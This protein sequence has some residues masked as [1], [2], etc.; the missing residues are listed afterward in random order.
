[1]CRQLETRLLAQL[2][3]PGPQVPG[4]DQTTPGEAVPEEDVLDHAAA[5]DEQQLLRDDRDAVREGGSGRGVVDRPSV[6]DQ[7]ALVRLDEPGDHATEGRLAR[8]VL[9]HE[10]VDDAALE[11]QVDVRESRDAPEPLPD[12]A[13]LD[14]QRAGHVVRCPGRSG[15]AG[16]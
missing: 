1:M 2:A 14:V 12:T 9:S 5:R 8:A 13:D 4:P 3:V 11:R 7:R 10:A 15:G 16:R 6:D